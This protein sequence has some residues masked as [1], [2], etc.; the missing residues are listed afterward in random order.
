MR[1]ASEILESIA[2]K[3]EAFQESL[4]FTPP[5]ASSDT[6]GRNLLDG[7]LNF[8]ES[9]ELLP[10][11]LPLAQEDAE[12]AVAKGQQMQ[13]RTQEESEEDDEED[14]EVLDVE[15]SVSTVKAEVARIV[16]AVS[17]NDRVMH[18]AFEPASGVRTGASSL[19][20]RCIA[21]IGS[22]RTDLIIT[23]STML[24]NLAR[25]GEPCP[26]TKCSDW[27]GQA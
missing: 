6:A 10:A 9:A 2:Y 21:W 15:K 3:D 5:S 22:G 8:V 17:S 23:G 20:P 27:R 12:R 18:A 24:A 4:A 19:L 1:A 25:K 16:I 14:G 13:S 11:W 7:M 26:S